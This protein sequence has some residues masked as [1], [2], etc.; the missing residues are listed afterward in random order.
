MTKSIRTLVAPIA[1]ALACLVGNTAV[2]AGPQPTGDEV[3]RFDAAVT[4][5]GQININTA[6]AAELELLPGVGPSIAGRIVSYRAKHPFKQRNNIMR[7]KGVGPKTFD[8]IKEFL[9]VEGDTNLRI[10][11]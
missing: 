3:A 1:L 11:K 6:S 2:A 9:V 8:K 7:V 5:E 4:L 10:A